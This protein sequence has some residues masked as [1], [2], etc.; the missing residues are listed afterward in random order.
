MIIKSAG[1]SISEESDRRSLDLDADLSLARRREC[2]KKKIEMQLRRQRRCSECHCWYFR[3]LAFY[4]RRSGSISGGNWLGIAARDAAFANQHGRAGS[5]S[6]SWRN[7]NE[8]LSCSFWA[9]TLKSQ[10][11]SVAL[12][13]ATVWHYSSKRTDQRERTSRERRKFSSQT[14]HSVT[15]ETREKLILVAS[16]DRKADGSN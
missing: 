10:L 1:R 9:G 6:R 15:R 2:E 16:R 8:P 12:T 13:V 7:F 11:V 3:L 4:S 14:D 5:Q